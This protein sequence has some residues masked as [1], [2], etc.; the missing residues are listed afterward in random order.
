MART[1]TK[2][3]IGTCPNRQ[4]GETLQAAPA[5][6]T[7]VLLR[8][9]AFG[10]GVVQPSRNRHPHRPYHGHLG[11]IARAG[12]RNSICRPGQTLIATQGYGAI[13]PGNAFTRARKFC[14]QLDRTP[15]LRVL[16]GQYSFRLVRGELEQAEQLAKE[17]RHRG[18]VRNDMTWKRA[19]SYASGSVCCWL[20]KFIDARAYLE[21]ALALRDDPLHRAR[22]TAPED[23]YVS[24]L[25]YLFW[26]LLCLGC[27][28][29]ARLRQDEALDEARRL[30]PHTLAFALCLVW[31]G[32]RAIEGVKAAP[33]ML[34]SAEE[35]L[36]I[37]SEQSFPQW[38]GIGKIMRG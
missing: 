33:E 25:V 21:Y 19:G 16:M 24:G 12:S 30:S 9:L 26:T 37:S 36:A 38:L 6:D 4:R 5:L 23:P 7:Q 13:E 32:D 28:D 2:P 8:K 1:T 3:L 15:K 17:T 10:T 34:R 11:G 20:G 35:V 29:Q 22:T 31:M 18:E 27:G 14:E